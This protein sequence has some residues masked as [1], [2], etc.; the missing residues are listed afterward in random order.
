MRQTLKKW[1][2]IALGWTLLVLGVIGLFLP[3]LQGIL[4]IMLGLLVLSWHNPWAERLL[5][6]LIARFPRQHAAMHRW[7]HWAREK[8]RGWRGRTAAATDCDEDAKGQGGSEKSDRL[9]D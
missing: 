5:A 6:R 1:L 9:T 8:W 2:Q 7:A 4:F 3:I